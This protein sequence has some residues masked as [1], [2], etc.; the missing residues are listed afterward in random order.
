MKIRAPRE[1]GKPLPELPDYCPCPN[2][3]WDSGPHPEHPSRSSSSRMSALG[4]HRRLPPAVGVRA[5]RECGAARYSRVGAEK[6]RFQY[7]CLLTPP[8]HPPAAANLMSRRGLSS[9]SEG[10]FI[11]TS[12]EQIVVRNQVHVSYWF[13][14]P[15][16]PR[17]LVLPAGCPRPGGPSPAPP[18]L[19][20][21]CGRGGNGIEEWHSLY[22]YHPTPSAHR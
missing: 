15:V 9:H 10:V 14:P 17:L 1:L 7:L 20:A 2:T 16:A 6:H 19:V 13:C 22:P 5:S 21:Y 3:P 12:V 4:P 8:L 11:A 18:G